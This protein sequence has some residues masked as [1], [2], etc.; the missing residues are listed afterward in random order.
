[1]KLLVDMN[2]TPRWVAFLEEAGW[3]CKHWSVVGEARAT[4][5]LITNWA[6]ENEF[7]ILTNDLDFPQI[8]AH[9]RDSRPSVVLLR[10]EPLTPEVRGSALLFALRRFE[11]ELGVGAIATINWTGKLRIR[12]LP[13]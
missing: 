6:R 7:V 12:L 11:M 13:L 8:M 2:L 3:A 1:M 4:D 10:G 9:T 5:R